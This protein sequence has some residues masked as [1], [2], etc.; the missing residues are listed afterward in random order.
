MSVGAPAVLVEQPPQR[1]P[2]FLRQLLLRD[3][4]ENGKPRFRG[5]QI[6]IS[7]VAPV[8]GDVVA[9]RQQMPLFVEQKAVFEAPERVRLR[10]QA[11]DHRDALAR[12]R[13]RL[14]SRPR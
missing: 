5:E 10:C 11:L 7:R 6:V 13:A 14:R 12:A 2:A 3:A 9:D 8:L 4:D 1:E